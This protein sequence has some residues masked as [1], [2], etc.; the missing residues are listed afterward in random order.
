MKSEVKVGVLRSGGSTTIIGI[1]TQDT[2][3]LPS[4]QK[5]REITIPSI[6]ATSSI[7]PDHYM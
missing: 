5:L 4:S 3:A 7:R 6:Q 1:A 2:T